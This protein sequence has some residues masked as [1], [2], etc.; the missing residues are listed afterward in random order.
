MN[1]LPGRV[2]RFAWPAIIANISTPL[3]GLVDS[4]VLGHLPSAEY[5]GGVALGA[6]LF[7]FLFWAF[8][9]L[10]MGVTGLV[11]QSLG[12]DDK[13]ALGRWLLQSMALA[14]LASLLIMALFPLLIT[15]ALDGFKASPA[16]A[17]QARLYSEIRILSAPAVVTNY[18]LMG[19]LL[20][21]QQPRGPLL[22]LVA[23][24]VTNILLDLLLVLGFGLATRGAALAT[25]IADY[26]A[27]VLGLLWVLRLAG[28][29]GLVLNWRALRDL[30]ALR[31]LLLL[32]RHLF[33]RTLCL[34][35]AQAF[36]MAQGARLGDEMLAANALLLNLLMLI[37]HG[38]DGFA[39]AAEALTGKALGQ[40]RLDLFAAVVRVTGYCSLGAGL[41]FMLAFA[42]GGVRLLGLLTDIPGV[43]QL[44]Q[45]YLPWLVVM[46]LVAIWCFWLDGVFI[47][48]IKT[49]AM[50]WTTLVATVFFFIPGWYFSRSLGNH[51]LW[52]A[53]T[54]FMLARSLGLALVYRRIERRGEWLVT[55]RG[56]L[57]S[58][59]V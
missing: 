44:A 12:H 32:N 1:N 43:A 3:L 39:H 27:M 55:R 59:G 47:G 36:F 46:P 35:F 45:V 4:A 50:Q 25:V 22:M 38:L 40:G 20:G 34:L 17:E 58:G 56:A 41:L 18:A 37:S 16:V 31:R 42:L 26:L 52:L 19:W 10:R 2:W 13:P 5:L 8:G 48:A 14:L 30:R 24:N 9:F 53:Y 23:A 7:S 6:S 29:Q 28:S 21:M 51:G 11:S 15:P 33:V 54:L 57:T 49:R